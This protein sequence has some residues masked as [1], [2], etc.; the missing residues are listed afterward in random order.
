MLAMS[1]SITHVSLWTYQ[2]IDKP[3]GTIKGAWFDSLPLEARTAL[4]V[5]L[6]A[7]CGAYIA[8]VVSPVV[9]RVP[10]LICSP[11]GLRAYSL[12]RRSIQW[13]N[14]EAIRFDGPVLT[15]K[16]R[17]SDPDRRDL[18]MTLVNLTSRERIIEAIHHYRW[19]LVPIPKSLL[20]R[21]ALET[22]ATFRREQ[23][24]AKGI[25]IDARN[26]TG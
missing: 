12:R 4:V 21:R 8:L 24:P 7:F 14:I 15:V 23:R 11:D 1:L 3:F 5:M 2:R 9:F 25:Q 19:D 10:L 26:W 13:G 20:A 16:P 18:R 6:L 22:E 17:A